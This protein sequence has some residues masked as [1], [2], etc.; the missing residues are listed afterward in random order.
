MAEQSARADFDWRA[1]SRLLRARLFDSGR[2][3]RSLC[4]EIGVSLTDLSRASAG[5]VL[6]VHKV[7]AICDWLGT[8]PRAFYRP[9]LRENPV[10]SDCFSASNVKHDAAGVGI[11][12]RRLPA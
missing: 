1:F 10:K 9:P 11:D 12:T 2:G 5:Q 4:D 7:I 3:Y 8:E 6:A